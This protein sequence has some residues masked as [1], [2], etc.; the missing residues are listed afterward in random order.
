FSHHPFDPVPVNCQAESSLRNA[1]GYLRRR[2]CIQR[3]NLPL[4]PEQRRTQ[5]GTVSD[6]LRYCL[7]ADQ[8]FLFPETFTDRLRS[9]DYLLAFRMY[10]SSA[11]VI[12]GAAGT[13]AWMSSFKPA[14]STACAVVGPKAAIRVLFCLNFGKFLKREMMPEG[15][16]NTSTS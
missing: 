13:V 10:C 16:K 2:S 14:S 9:H 11:I 6:E 8:S 5:L 1:K 7:T 15:L 4:H 3:S 12:D